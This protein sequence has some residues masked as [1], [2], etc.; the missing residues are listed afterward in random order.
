MRTTMP[1]SFERSSSPLTDRLERLCR[2]VDDVR[3]R[4]HRRGA[5]S[6][7]READHPEVTTLSYLTVL[8]LVVVPVVALVVFTL[9]P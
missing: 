1:E 3:V 6:A 5:E 7:L 9:F 8:A 4:G 2:T